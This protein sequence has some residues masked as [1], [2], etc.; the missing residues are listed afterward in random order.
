MS[1]NTF[2]HCL[3]LNQI[4]HGLDSHVLSSN[5][6]VRFGS[7]SLWKQN[8]SKAIEIL[9]RFSTSITSYLQTS[10]YLEQKPRFVRYLHSSVNFFIFD[11]SLSLTNILVF[12]GESLLYCK[13]WKTCT[14]LRRGLYSKQAVF[15]SFTRRYFRIFRFT[16]G[17]LLICS[18]SLTVNT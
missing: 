5:T 2:F 8:H 17:R 1:C 18:T 15:K 16:S 6:F 14:S 4:H 13:M 7:C 10:L 9:S 11:T 12:R 3:T